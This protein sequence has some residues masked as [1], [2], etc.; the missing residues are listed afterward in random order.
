MVYSQAKQ[1]QAVSVVTLKKTPR[2]DVY[3]EQHSLAFDLSTST[4]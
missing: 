1:L 2:D 4:R 3:L